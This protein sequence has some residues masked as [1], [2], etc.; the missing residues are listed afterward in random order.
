MTDQPTIDLSPGAT[1]LWQ[2]LRAACRSLTGLDWEEGFEHVAWAAVTSRTGIDDGLSTSLRW[3]AENAG[4]W[5]RVT[6]G[7]PSEVALRYW[8]EA[9][10]ADEAPAPTDADPAVQLQTA[11][12]ATG[13]ARC[14]ARIQPGDTYGVVRVGGQPLGHCCARCLA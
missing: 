4:C 13:C 9:P 12:T 5:L 2:L 11:L 7:V 14:G 3:T 8:P 10:R 6:D 1:A